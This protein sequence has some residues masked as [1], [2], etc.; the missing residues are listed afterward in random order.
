MEH[1]IFSPIDNSRSRLINVSVPGHKRRYE[2]VFNYHPDQAESVEASLATV[3]QTFEIQK[4]PVVDEKTQ[5]KWTRI[6]FWTI[7]CFVAGI[8]LS[9]LLKV[10]AG[11]GE[12][13]PEESGG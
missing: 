12:K 8:L 11:V 5:S 7:G 3:L 6:A 1:D 4:K 2:I 13:E 10:L 9:L